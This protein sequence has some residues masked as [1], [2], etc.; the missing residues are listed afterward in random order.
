[1][2]HLDKDSRNSRLVDKTID[3]SA[4]IKVVR[5]A[6]LPKNPEVTS[7]SS[8]DLPHV[9]P[10]PV[11]LALLS[12]TASEPSNAHF[13]S[14]DTPPPADLASESTNTV[15][16][17]SRRQRAAVSYAE[18]NLRD[19][20]RRPTKELV[21]AVSSDVKITRVQSTK[22]NDD[23]NRAASEHL[24]SERSPAPTYIKQE[25]DRDDQSQWKSLPSDNSRAQ[26]HA[27]EPTSPL[28]KKPSLVD[29]DASGLP[30]TVLTD[31]RRRSSLLLQQQQQQQ[32]QPPHE[33]FDPN[34]VPAKHAFSTPTAHQAS[35]TSMTA[36]PLTT[37]SS[38]STIAALVAG[39]QKRLSRAREAAAARGHGQHLSL[40]DIR[41]KGKDL[42]LGQDSG[43]DRGN[44]K[45][46]GKDIFEIT[47]SGPDMRGENS[48]VSGKETRKAEAKGRR[49]SSVEQGGSVRGRRR[50]TMVS[51][52][53]SG[54]G[55]VA[56]ESKETGG[57]HSKPSGNVLGS[58]GGKDDTIGRA[59]RAA[60]RRRSMVL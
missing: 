6:L 53:S 42:K 57:R 23:N 12:P 5:P 58:G 9:T 29:S 25:E 46:D 8:A 55:I 41:E 13:D 19:K 33:P 18:P 27:A 30:S 43:Q 2:K 11:D 34:P 14:R 56:T 47:G 50:E 36:A 26:K 17:P 39:S 15:G 20:M 59:E 16:R 4:V 24:N 38:N 40:S 31:R 3:K 32:Q 21:D 37:S 1:M 49:M 44:G 28:S 51:T 48:V 7:I 22:H 35:L 60:M 52:N 54:D 10:A 45:G